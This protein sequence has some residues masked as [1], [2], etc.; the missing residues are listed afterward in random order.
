LPIEVKLLSTH[1]LRMHGANMPVPYGY[2]APPSW[3]RRV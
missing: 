3:G 1:T 2:S